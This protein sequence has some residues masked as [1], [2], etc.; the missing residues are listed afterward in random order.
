LHG[1]DGVAEA[2][3]EDAPFA[4]GEDHDEGLVFAGAAGG[5]VGEGGGQDADVFGRAAQTVVEFVFGV[6]PFGPW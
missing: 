1:F 5:L 6:E 3:V 2:G 4:V